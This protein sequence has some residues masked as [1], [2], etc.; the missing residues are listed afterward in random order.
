[1][2]GKQ[3]IIMAHV[4]VWETG[5][6][7]RLR[8]FLPICGINPNFQWKSCLK[9][10][11]FSS[12]CY[13]KLSKIFPSR[14][15]CSH[16]SLVAFFCVRCIKAT[17]RTPIYTFSHNIWISRLCFLAIASWH[18]LSI[19]G[20]KGRLGSY[21][22]TDIVA[23]IRSQKEHRIV[24]TKGLTFRRTEDI[25]PVPAATRGLYPALM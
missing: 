21:S 12:Y 10:H 5:W 24:N 4:C 8:Y 20:A 18:N 2:L 15:C 7:M 3:E 11:T 23:A 19:L 13:Y 22:K 17:G 25:F 16:K 1:M 6:D 9:T 14:L